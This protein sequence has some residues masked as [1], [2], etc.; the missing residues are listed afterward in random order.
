[1]QWQQ[2]EKQERSPDLKN[3]IE[4]FKEHKEMGETSRLSR[5]EQTKKD[6][7]KTQQE[8][9]QTRNSGSGRSFLKRKTMSGNL[10]FIKK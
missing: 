7:E 3:K 6:R 9:E 1:M 8:R 4:L 5:P 2:H 10:K